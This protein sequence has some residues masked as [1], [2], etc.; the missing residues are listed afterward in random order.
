MH[1]APSLIQIGSKA[2]VNLALVHD[3]IP[4]NLFELLSVDP[5]GIVI[6]YKITDGTSIGFILKLSDGSISWFF[7]EELG[8]YELEGSSLGF[9][10]GKYEDL[11]F[12]LQEIGLS[13][14]MNGKVK[15]YKQPAFNIG[16]K[17]IDLL[18]PFNFLKW[19]SYSLKDV[20]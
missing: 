16:T 17:M 18:N 3:R 20:Y 7:Q 2:K 8:D 14:M 19:L 5:V 6:D 10:E 4:N 13:K 1:S 15:N 11:N 9:N 12:S